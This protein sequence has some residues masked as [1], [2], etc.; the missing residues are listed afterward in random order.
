VSDGPGHRLEFRRVAADEPP[1]AELIEQM[2]LE[3]E[4]HYGRIDG[5]GMPVVAASQFAPPDGACLVGYAEGEPICVGAVKRLGDGLCEIK[6]MYVAPAGR[7][8]GAARALLGALEDA[9]RSLG[10]E[11]VRLDTGPEQPH[12]K[13]LYTSAGYREIDDYNRNPAAS[14]WAEKEL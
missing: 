2:V 14:F 12:A 6:R 10:Y 3:L 13:A 7:S 4:R 5:P 8:R 1:A 9:A 11:R